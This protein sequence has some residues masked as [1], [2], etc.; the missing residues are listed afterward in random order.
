MSSSDDED[1]LRPLALSCKR[2]RRRWWMHI[3]EKRLLYPGWP[4]SYKNMYSLAFSI[5]ISVNSS[6]IPYYPPG[7]S[8]S[9]TQMSAARRDL[10][11]SVEPASFLFDGYD[12]M[13]HNT[14]RK[15]SRRAHRSLPA[16]AARFLCGRTLNRV[17]CYSPLVC[18]STCIGI[19]STL[20]FW[21]RVF[22]LMWSKY[23]K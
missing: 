4:V 12:A 23:N 15:L 7:N 3:N 13:L 17:R 14:V 6:A 5:N 9:K 1:E 18:V 8:V 16:A 22:E 19:V 20:H 10:D 2:K 21:K 11:W